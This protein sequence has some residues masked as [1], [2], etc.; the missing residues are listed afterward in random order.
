MKESIDL[1]TATEDLKSCC[2]RLY[3]QDFVRI[4]LG[5]SFHPGGLDLTAQLGRAMGLKP[6]LRV[7]D[8][9]SGTGTSA[10]H[11]AETFGS[12]VVGVD[13]GNE[14]VRVANQEAAR[15]GLNDH[16]RFEH[17][18]SERLPFE[19]ASF[20]AIV[21]ECAFCTFPD[22]AAAA[23]E[24]YRVLGPGGRV[25][26]GDITRSSTLGA[27][28]RSLMAWVACIADAQ[29]VEGY[30]EELMMAGFR[31]DSVTPHD[32]VLTEMVNQI[33][34]KLLG[35]EIAVG[36]KKIDLPEVDFTNAKNMAGAALEAINS[37]QLGYAILTATRP[38]D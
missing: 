26:L 16:V 37:G 30:Q 4:L 13:Y 20:D 29:T 28:L 15:R 31:M 10:L 25:G 22:K 2:A 34:G 7:L 5:D 18:D 14:N 9:A 24:F 11:I 27:E 38:G 6:E 17:G 35:L 33:R 36:L 1:P 19:D 32:D 21:C 3:E 23:G 12:E 8:V